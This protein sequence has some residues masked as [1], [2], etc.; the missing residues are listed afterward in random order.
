[1]GQFTLPDLKIVDCDAFCEVIFSASH[2]RICSGTFSTGS[3]SKLTALPIMNF[4]YDIQKI[5]KKSGNVFPL[6][7]PFT[8]REV[9]RCGKSFSLGFWLPFGYLHMISIVH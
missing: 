4:V 9:R 5:S 7:I 2:P 3:T 6:L 1:M 8:I